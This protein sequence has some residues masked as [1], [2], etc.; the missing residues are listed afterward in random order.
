MGF[1][2]YMLTYSLAWLLHLL[3][4]RLLYL[5]SDFLYLLTYRLARY[6][7]EVVYSNLRKALPEKTDQQLKS[8]AKRF[9]HHLCD[10]ILESAV[11]HFHTE[12][13]V[14]KRV[15]FS[16]TEVLEAYRKQG[17]MVMAVSAH[18]G[19][20]EYLATLGLATTYPVV[21][22]YK[23]L[24]NK[25]IDRMVR[26][27][28]ERLGSI[29]VPMEQIARKLITHHKDQDPVVT[30]FL[31]DQRPLFHNIQYW[32]TFMGLDTPLYLGTEKL[33]RKLDAAVVFIKVRKVRR[34]RYV[35]EVEDLGADPGS[36]EPFEITEKHVRILE[37]LIHE[38]PEYWLW[39]HKR[40]KH[41][42]PTG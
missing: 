38:A 23:P 29:P 41:K 30:L 16:N 6:R 28:R 22:I 25:Y 40:W 8:I 26:G 4:E 21:A 2:G 17:K 13:S 27:N 37:N 19:N 35:I 9:Y 32:T 20:W 11:S 42:K 39:S 15:S 1:L 5:C 18:Y 10:V 3:P 31:S 34:G 36:M 24:K 33:A 12:A 14:R 7:R